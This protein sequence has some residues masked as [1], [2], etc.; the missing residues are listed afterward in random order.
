MDIALDFARDDL[1]LA[2]IVGGIL[3]QA[4]DQQRHVHHQSLHCPLR[5]ASDVLK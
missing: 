3:D 5:I 2:V 1:G 4:T